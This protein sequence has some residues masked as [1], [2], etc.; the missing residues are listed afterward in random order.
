MEFV[1]VE[2]ARIMIQET[3]SEQYIFF[4]EKKGSRSFPIVIGLFEALAIDR[5]I[6]EVDTPRPMTHDL[7]A[8]V[9]RNLG[10]TLERI[11][12]TD[13]RDNTFFARLDVRRNGET[14]EVDARPSDAVALAVHFR[15]PILVSE[16]VIARVSAAPTTESLEEL[17]KA[18]REATEAEPEEEGEDGDEE[19]EEN[20]EKGP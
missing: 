5:R 10:G 7:L 18:L 3:N 12:I 16:D 8:N 17:E 20:E 6:R 9:I 1:E 11:A 14:V 4:R 15:C 19:D 13:L 2:L